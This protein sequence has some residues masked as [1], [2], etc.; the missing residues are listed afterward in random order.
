MDDLILLIFAVFVLIL[1]F[2]GIFRKQNLILIFS[3]IGFI[4]LGVFLLKGFSYV[5][6]SNITTINDSFKIIA[7]NVSTWNSDFKT[8]LWAFFSLFGLFLILVS[9][10]D[11]FRTG[12]KDFLEQEPGNEEEE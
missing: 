2:T 9:A 8:Y 3:G 1:F 7:D 5:S 4:L 11:F 10:I 6:G 12:K